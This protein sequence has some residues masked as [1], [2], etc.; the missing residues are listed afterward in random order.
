MVSIKV[1]PDADKEEVWNAFLKAR[2]Q[3]F[4]ISKEQFLQMVSPVNALSS[5]CNRYS[6]NELW[7]MLYDC[8]AIR[9]R[10]F[11]EKGPNRGL[12][13]YYYLL[14]L[15]SIMTGCGVFEGERSVVEICGL[16][17]DDAK[18][19]KAYCSGRTSYEV[20]DEQEKI[21]KIIKRWLFLHK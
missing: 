5:P 8:K 18:K 20:K 21:V 1:R 14:N 4:G 12:L 15:I 19:A 13:K 16:L 9:K 2:Q 3:M 11:F 17:I 7:E 6:M 10:L